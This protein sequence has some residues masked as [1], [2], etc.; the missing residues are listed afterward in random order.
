MLATA[1][2]TVQTTTSKEG[3]SVTKQDKVL[4]LLDLACIE[5]ATASQTNLDMWPIVSEARARLTLLVDKGADPVP[6]DINEVP[7]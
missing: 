6:L 4:F 3:G 7:F 2:E 1:Q 5:A